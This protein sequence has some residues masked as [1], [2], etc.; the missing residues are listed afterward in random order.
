MVVLIPISQCNACY[1]L[2]VDCIVLLT[3]DSSRVGRRNPLHSGFQLAAAGYLS[4]PR[5][6]NGMTSNG[7]A[8]L[9]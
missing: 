6:R 7:A 9:K 2:M 4:S 8:L 3:C 1:A 5:H